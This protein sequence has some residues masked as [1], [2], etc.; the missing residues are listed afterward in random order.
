MAKAGRPIG[1]SLPWLSGS[2]PQCMP[3]RDEIFHGPPWE[4][5]R[6]AGKI[7]QGAGFAGEGACAPRFMASIHVHKLEVLP[8]D[9]PCDAGKRMHVL[10]SRPLVGGFT[11]TRLLI[12]RKPLEE[13]AGVHGSNIAEFVCEGRGLHAADLLE[14]RRKALGQV[15]ANLVGCESRT[16]CRGACGYSGPV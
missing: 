3:E 16:A 11:V 2:W 1:T 10:D 7:E 5:W 12:F 8:L 13:W 9:E 4:R 15:R 6:L 14:S